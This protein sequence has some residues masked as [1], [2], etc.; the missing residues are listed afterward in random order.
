MKKKNLKF[1]ENRLK[2]LLRNRAT[3]QELTGDHEPEL[4][5]Y[6]WIRSFI[7]NEC[8]DLYSGALQY[9][10]ILHHLVMTFKEHMAKDLIE[11][12]ERELAENK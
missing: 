8:F 9:N 4:F 2:K 3:W 12:V 6:E 1:A 7:E 11:M 10:E 5:C